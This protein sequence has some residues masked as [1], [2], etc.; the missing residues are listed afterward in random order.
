[1]SNEPVFRKKSIDRISSP[2]LESPFSELL[3]IVPSA[4]LELET[5]SSAADVEEPPQPARKAATEKAEI[6]KRALR[7][8][9]S[10]LI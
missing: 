8:K 3:E 6:A 1:M 2:E 7:I 10:N 4:S 5:D 9:T